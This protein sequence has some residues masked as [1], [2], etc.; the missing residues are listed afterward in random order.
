MWFRVSVLLLL[1]IVA[2]TY[3]GDKFNGVDVGKP[4]VFR[5]DDDNP[6]KTQQQAYNDLGDIPSYSAYLSVNK[7]TNSNLFFWYFPSSSLISSRPSMHSPEALTFQAD[8]KAPLLLWLQGG[9]GGSSLFGLFNE[10]GPFSVDKNLTLVPREYAWT[11]KYSMLYI[12][13]PVGTG[14]SYTDSEEGYVTNEAEV[15]RD[16]YIGL[17]AFFKYF[18]EVAEVDFYITGESYAGKYVP[19][20][21]EKIHSMNANSVRKTM[22]LKGMAIG[23]GLCD[24]QNMLNYGDY[25]K[26]V[27]LFAKHYIGLISEKQRLYFMSKQNKIRELIK[28]NQSMRAFRE[29]DE[30]LNGD[31][32]PY[33]SYFYNVTGSNYYFNYLQF[34]EPEDFSYYSKYVNKADVRK[35]LHVGN[36]P[37]NDGK[38]VEKHLMGDVMNSVAHKVKTILDANYKVLFYSGQLDIIVAYP[39]TLNFLKNLEWSGQAEYLNATRTIW[40]I[41][42]QPKP[43]VA[44]YITEAKNLKVVLVRDAGHIVPYDQPM[45]AFDLISRF[46]EDKPF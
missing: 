21:T 19:A 6:K 44:G 22:N 9:P 30:L 5:L 38:A 17:S 13:N 11:K 7:T 18:P 24:P 14:F 40:R 31:L 2:H 16:L 33:T 8:P 10:H 43:T 12:D 35:R 4:V 32:V 25:L 36:R 27:G 46:I 34:E 1:F 42:T 15:A 3:A 41:D 45:H 29:F 28:T 23:D 39:L 20:I 26:Y 37:F